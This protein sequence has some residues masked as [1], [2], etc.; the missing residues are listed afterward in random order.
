M[1]GSRQ[2]HIWQMLQRGFGTK[3]GKDH[4]VW[5]YEKDQP[6]KQTV[7]RLHGREKYFYGPEGSDADTNITNYENEIQSTIQ[8]VRQLANGADVDAEFSATLIAH[9]EMR[10]A[11]LREEV[12]VS[13]QKG[14][15]ALSNALASPSALRRAMHTYLNANPEKVDDLLGQKF[16][17]NSD[18]DRVIRLIKEALNHVPG[19]ALLEAIGPLVPQIELLSNSI[20]RVAKDAQNKVLAESASSHDRMGLYRDFTYRVFRPVGGQFILPDTTVCFTKRG[21]AAPFAQKTDELEAVAL[22]LSSSVAIVGCRSG[23]PPFSLKTLNRLLAACSFK[24]FIAR[25]D[26]ETFRGLRGRIGKYAKL[27]DDRDLDISIDELDLR[28]AQPPNE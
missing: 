20:P 21:G 22:P 3:R 8:D 24:S 9:L 26:N 15:T 10:S 19:E 25:E 11:F 18:R 5:I 23:E 6:P 1:A 12:S 17:P 7:T 14:I 13:F 28:P 16:V 2:H 27:I 4:H